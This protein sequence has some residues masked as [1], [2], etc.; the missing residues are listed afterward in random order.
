M[1]ATVATTSAQRLDRKIR[2]LANDIGQKLDKLEALLAEAKQAEIHTA[3]GFTTWTAYVADV[4]SQWPAESVEQ[5]RQAVALLSREGMSQRAIATAVGVSQK[6]V[7]RD[8]DQVS[9]DDS[10]EPATV[11]GLDGKTYPRK[12][13]SAPQKPKEKAKR[14]S[15]REVERE[16]S[17]MLVRF[18]REEHAAR[19][20]AVADLKASLKAEAEAERERM[21]RMQDLASAEYDRYRKLIAALEKQKTGIISDEEYNLIRSCLHPDSRNSVTEEKL[22]AAFRVFNDPRIKLAL[23][24][25]EAKR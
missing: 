7:D 19:R 17:E 10:P 13:Q 25:S 2:L 11:T 22:A 5:R 6:T 12:S 24:K 3:L 1:N 20:E 21:R 14:R 8:L 16:H 18:T 4:A 9:H 23:T 15:V